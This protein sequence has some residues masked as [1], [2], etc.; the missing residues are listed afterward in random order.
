[1]A[2]AGRALREDHGI[3]PVIYLKSVW[4]GRRDRVVY[5]PS[6]LNQTSAMFARPVP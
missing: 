6:P 4:A 2:E 3:L 1:M 5:D